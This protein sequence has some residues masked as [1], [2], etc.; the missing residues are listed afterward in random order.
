MLLENAEPNPFNFSIAGRACASI[1]SLGKQVHA[2]VINHRFESNLPVMNSILDM[3]CRFGPWTSMMIDYGAHGY[4]KEAV[5]LFDKMVTSGATPDRIVF[6]AVLTA[7]SLAGLVDEGKW[8]EFAKVRK[9]IRGIGDKKEAERSW[10]EVR[11]QVYS[12]VVGNKIGSCNKWVYEILDLLV[13]HMKQAG[14]VCHSDYLI[15]DPGD[16]T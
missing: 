7:C 2:T 11:N 14:Y 13:L 8:R 1:G 10:I 16:G 12:F 15:Y 3:Y 6:M 9:H 4:G 5:A